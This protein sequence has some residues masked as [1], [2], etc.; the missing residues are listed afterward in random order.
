MKMYKY[1]HAMLLLVTMLVLLVASACGNSTP[2]VTT[3]QP[4]TEAAVAPA[5]AEPT[6]A[7]AEPA[8][9][10]PTE[11]PA[12]P[13]EAPAE[14]AAEPASGEGGEIIFW[15]RDSATTLVQPIIDQW[16]ATHPNKIK[17]TFIPA[18]QFVQKFSAAMAGGEP[19]DLVAVDLIY[20]PA[21]AAAGQMT[22]ITNL[23]NGLA[24]KDKLSP[25]HMRLGTYDGKIYSVPFNAEGS[26]LV[27]NKDLFKQAGL[28][29]EKPPTNWGEMEEA[30][31]KITA[32]GNDTYGFYFSGS[33]AGCNA[34]TVLPYLWASGGD[35]LSEDGKTATVTDPN[36]KA[37]L[38]MLRRMWE[39]KN[40]PETAKVDT[41]TDFFNTFTS[42]KI[43]MVGSGAF[44]I[45][46]L[47]KDFPDLDFGVA[48]LP[49]KDGGSASFA[50]GDTIGIPTGST[51]VEEAF[52]FL[53]WFLSEEVQIEYLAKNG[54]LPLR[55]DLIDNKYSQE[56]PRYITVAK[57][58]FEEGRTPFLVPY[59]EIFNDAN[60]P[61]LAML[62]KAVFDGDIDGAVTDAQE[63][64]TQILSQ[65]AQ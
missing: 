62:Q 8:A 45:A 61:W 5:A 56:D 60:G 20:M 22:E 27:Y 16:N 57:A 30:A 44:A 42:G 29:P 2:A 11:A 55:L 37:T 50:G 23:V 21:Y 10:E 58:M 65:S 13:T 46:T 53:N 52:E 34:F 19:P 4:A 14:P 40:I 49:G 48:P 3:E 18:D 33:C 35:V 32:L 6:A 25:S 31:K 59:N 24:F 7:P 54:G 39:G 64:F 47:K 26:V 15:A 9:A 43:G 12:E 41:G 63:S 38:E 36:V 51:K 28:D 1:S 17:P